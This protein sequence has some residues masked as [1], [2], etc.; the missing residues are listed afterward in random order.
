MP[1]EKSFYPEFPGNR[2]TARNCPLASGKS[3]TKRAGTA[4][5]HDNNTDKKKDLKQNNKI[6]VQINNINTSHS[7]GVLFIAV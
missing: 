1:L 6:H 5:K 4:Q 2:S 7:V 3:R